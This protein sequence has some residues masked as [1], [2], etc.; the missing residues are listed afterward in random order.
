MRNHSCPPRFSDCPW[1]C[2]QTWGP[3]LDSTEATP[4]CCSLRIPTPTPSATGCVGWCFPRRPAALGPARGACSCGSPTP[5][6][7]DSWPQPQRRFSSFSHPTCKYC[8]TSTP[9]PLS[10]RAPVVVCLLCRSSQLLK[11]T[12]FWGPEP[13][14]LF[15]LGIEKTDKFKPTT[16]RPPALHLQPY[17]SVSVWRGTEGG[18]VDAHRKRHLE[19]DYL[20]CGNKRKGAYGCCLDLMT[21]LAKH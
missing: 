12:S 6:A 7:T 16:S 4:T 9:A 15:S 8:R 11:P 19:E 13:L 1:G 20:T 21:C 10:L 2:P 17:S 14:A 5:S 3:A 18:G